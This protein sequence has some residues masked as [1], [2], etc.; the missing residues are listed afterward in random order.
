MT[1]GDKRIAEVLDEQLGDVD[2]CLVDPED[3][4]GLVQVDFT[5]L[6]PQPGELAG[7]SNQL[8]KDLLEVPRRTGER[9]LQHPVIQLFVETRWLRTRWMFCISSVL[10][11]LFLLTFSSSSATP[12]SPSSGLS[13]VTLRTM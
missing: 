1:N 9:I 7:N 3:P 12:S 6:L 2:H 13:T 11:L 8:L 4:E 5:M 10:Y